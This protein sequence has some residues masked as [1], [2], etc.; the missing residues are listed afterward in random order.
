MLLFGLPAVYEYSGQ[1]FVYYFYVFPH[2]SPYLFPVAMC[3]QTTSIY[4]TFTVTLERFVAVCHPLRARALCTYGRAKLYVIGCWTFSLLFNL[5]HFWD[6]DVRAVQYDE[7]TV[8]YCPSASELRSDRDYIN[9]YVH[10]ASLVVLYVVPFTTLAI[11]NTLIYRQVRRANRERQRLSRTEKREIGLATMLLCVVLVFFVCNV[12]SMVNNVLEAI[13][14][15]INEYLVKASN[16]LVTFNSSVNFVIYVIFGEK[17]KR[18]F[19]LLFCTGRVGRE[20]PDGLVHD[21]S[22]FSNGE[23]RCSGRFQRHG[24]NRSVSSGRTNGTSLRT[25]RSVRVNRAPSPGP[26]VYYPARDSSLR[27]NAYL[28]R[29]SSV[30]NGNTTPEWETHRNGVAGLTM[31]ATEG[32]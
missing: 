15:L 7:D 5:P 29:S 18:I 3:A 30:Q 13:Y 9:I 10:W 28:P 4:L 6:V 20:S 31:T 12:L 17:F 1:L 16:L 23:N 19:L 22:S 2:L 27:S 11:L 32:L 21:D 14:D 8:V 24:T 25:T 26:I